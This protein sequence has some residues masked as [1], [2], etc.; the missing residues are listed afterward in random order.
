MIDS[1]INKFV[2]KALDKMFKLVGF[3]GFDEEFTKHPQWY[4]QKS[5][6]NETE[7][8]YKEWFYKTAQKDLK[9]NKITIEKE[10]SWFNL[11][12]GWKVE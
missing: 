7:R 5:W 2:K 4:S 9:W 11:M 10:Y 12:Y 6:S 3:S 1:K 8:E